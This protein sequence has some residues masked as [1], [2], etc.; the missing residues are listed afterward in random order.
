MRR[1]L[2]LILVVALLLPAIMP[3]PVYA[4]SPKSVTLPAL[5]DTY[6]AQLNPTTN[7]GTQELL[8]TYDFAGALQRPILAFD[9]PSYVGSLGIEEIVSA[10]FRLYYYSYGSYNPKGKTVWA[11]AL[12]QDGWV[13]TQATWNIYKTDNNW[14]T[15]GGDYTEVDKASTTVPTSYGWMTWDVTDIV[16]DAFGGD[17]EV[18]LLVRMANE[19]QGS[20]TTSTTTWYSRES[21]QTTLRPQ[22]VITYRTLPAVTTDSSSAITDDQA[23]LHGTVTDHGGDTITER[24]FQYGLTQTGTWSTN[25][26][27]SYST[28][29]YTRDATGLDP[30]TTYH[31]RAYAENSI[32]TSYGSWLSFTTLDDPEVTTLA[33]TN[34][35]TTTARLRGYVDFD[36]NET[37]EYRFQWGTATGV[38]TFSTAWTGAVTTGQYFY[39]DLSGLV[40]DTDYFFVAELR[41]SVGDDVGAELSFKTEF[42]L[43][44]PTTF[45]AHATSGTEISLSWVKPSGGDNTRIQ[46][47]AGSYPANVNDGTTVYTAEGSSTTVGGRTP[48]TTYYFRAWSEAEGDFSANYTNAMTTTLAGAVDVD[49]V[50]PDEPG[51]WF[52]IPSTAGITNMPF[53]AQVNDLWD[54]FSLPHITGWV[55]LAIFLAALAAVATMRGGM[56][57]SLIAASFVIVVASWMLAIPF[58]LILLVFTIGGGYAWARSRV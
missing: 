51:G 43:L 48:G 35:G 18:H 2:L 13:E 52:S 42:E 32:G 28:G 55:G 37:C 16:L 5:A 25:Q 21:S 17:D 41:N 24:G 30:N 46:M 15:A 12:T 19:A 57:M 11:C 29:S 4:D 1:L 31:F 23:T 58:M 44:P 7:Y 20:V 39:A 34:I 47:K 33:A 54:S 22:L 14:T 40:M 56:W 3:L 53:Y 50:P 9:L 36:G 27:G 49:P 45:S 38:Y 6:L 8:R 10:S 26:T